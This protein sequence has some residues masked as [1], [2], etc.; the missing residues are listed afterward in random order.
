MRKHRFLC[1]NPIWEKTRG[2][3]RE[4]SLFSEGYSE[5]TKAKTLILSLNSM[6]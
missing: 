6:E 1:E 5:F 2:V 4:N 3:K